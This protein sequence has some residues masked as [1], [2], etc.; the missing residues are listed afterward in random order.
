MINFA[1]AVFC[2]QKT[3]VAKIFSTKRRAGRRG[4]G[5]VDVGGETPAEKANSGCRQTT[6]I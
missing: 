6:R 1:K 2:K 3:V 5:A 4:G